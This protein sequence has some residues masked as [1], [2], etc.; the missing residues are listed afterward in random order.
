MWI[1]CCGIY[2]NREMI[3]FFETR[4]FFVEKMVEET[5]LLSC[6]LLRTKSKNIHDNVSQWCMNLKVCLGITNDYIY[7]ILAT[8]VQLWFTEF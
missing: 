8:K 3:R 5:K 2:G 4:N 7:H 1:A 6:N